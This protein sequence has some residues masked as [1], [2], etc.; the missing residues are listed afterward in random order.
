MLLHVL[1]LLLVEARLR[2]RLRTDDEPPASAGQ[3]TAR[4]T[5][6]VTASAGVGP[7]AVAAVAAGRA[8]EAG[9][10]GG[11]CGLGEA[12][13]GAAATAGR[14]TAAQ[15][16]ATDS[17]NDSAPPRPRFGCGPRGGSATAAEYA[18][19]TP[20]DRWKNPAF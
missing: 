6:S 18:G 8:G 17:A 15:R 7:A 9:G 12:R 3:G 19:Q 1:A 13:Q 4:E 20:T 16:A 14:E 10:E 5:A 11:T 2:R